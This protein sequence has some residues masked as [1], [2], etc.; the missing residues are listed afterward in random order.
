MI[1]QT[2]NDALTLVGRGQPAGELLRRYWQPVALSEEL[3]AGDPVPVML[4]GEE[5]VLFRDDK[6]RIGL[7]D[8]HCS[9]RAADLSFGRVEGGGIRC[10]YHGWVFDVNGKCLEQ[11]CEPAGKEFKERIQHPYYPCLE[12]AGLVFAYL[13]PGEPPQLPAY[14]FLNA[15]E[16]YVHVNKVHHECNYLQANEGNIDPAHL[17]VLHTFDPNQVDG[18][19]KNLSPLAI[20]DP[21]PVIESDE[22]DYGLRIHT[23]RKVGEQ[24][25]YIR[26]TNFIMPNLSAFPGGSLTGGYTVNWHVPIDDE[27]HWKYQIILNREYDPGFLDAKYFEDGITEDYMPVRNKA[28]RWKQNRAIMKT[29]SFAGIGDT[30]GSNFMAQDAFATVSQGGIQDRTKENP[31]YGDKVIIS[32]RRMILQGIEDIQKGKDP[33]GVIRDPAKNDMSH[34]VIKGEVIESA[35]NWKERWKEKQEG[36]IIFR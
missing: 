11:P 12:R 31:G 18:K 6:G 4:M 24:R 36:E 14:E 32:A 5:L 10:L 25:F 13:G 35:D 1:K 26:V 21:T 33:V 8:V 23:L 22:T 17:S 3:L 7:L 34:L 29:W 16:G 19:S 15:P 2:V 28:N 9:H 20:K 27:N 30:P